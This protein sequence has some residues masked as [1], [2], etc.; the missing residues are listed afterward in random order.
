MHAT[1]LSEYNHEV[2]LNSILK[3]AIKVDSTSLIIMSLL[4]LF[5]SA[6][7]QWTRCLSHITSWHGSEA[8]LMISVEAQSNVDCLL[9]RMIVC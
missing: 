4:L 2:E 9:L 3:I 1:E 8:D 6:S 7:V 5:A